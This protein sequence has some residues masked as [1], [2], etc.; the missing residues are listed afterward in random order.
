MT[1]R[2]GGGQRKTYF[3]P[4]SPEDP[5]NRSPPSVPTWIR[6]QQT[7]EGGMWPGRGAQ[8]SRAAFHSRLSWCGCDQELSPSRRGD[9]TAEDERPSQA[10]RLCRG[11]WRGEP[12]PDKREAVRKTDQQRETRSQVPPASQAVA[13]GPGTLSERRRYS[14]HSPQPPHTHSVLPRREAGCAGGR[15]RNRTAQILF[16]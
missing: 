16:S 10:R 9:P 13:G 11:S 5:G 2:N 12:L 6:P 4:S 8:I 7:K 1:K 15:Q 14:R 3:C